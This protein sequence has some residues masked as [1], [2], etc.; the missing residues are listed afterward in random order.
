[1][2]FNVCPHDVDPRIEPLIK[3]LN[4]VGLKTLYSCEGDEEP[5]FQADAYF[6]LDLKSI[7]NIM[8]DKESISI[9]FNP[10]EGDMP[11][12]KEDK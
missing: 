10:I 9:Y 6:T 3:A 7:N 5:G 12:N 1:M 4:R 2:R 8:I 11:W